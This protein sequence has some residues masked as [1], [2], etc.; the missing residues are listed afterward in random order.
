MSVL[1]WPYP[2]SLITIV[3]IILFNILRFGNQIGWNK[4]IMFNMI[5]F[6]GYVGIPTIY[7]IYDGSVIKTREN[8]LNDLGALLNALPFLTST[9]SVS[10][11]PQKKDTNIQISNK[12]G[13]IG[14]AISFIWCL[15]VAIWL[16]GKIWDVSVFEP[17]LIYFFGW[18]LP[19]GLLPIVMVIYPKITKKYSKIGSSYFSGDQ[20]ANK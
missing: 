14:F 13:Y 8:L 18:I 1:Q 5:L 2:Y 9:Y 6:L 12:G 3:A 11:L 15:I 7:L 17:E 16:S 20:G 19:L 10:V 4:A